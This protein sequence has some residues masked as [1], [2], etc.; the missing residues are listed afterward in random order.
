MLKKSTQVFKKHEN[1]KIQLLNNLCL[2]L[3]K[4]F[5]IFKQYDL[6]KKHT[7]KNLALN[8]DQ[9]EKLCMYYSIALTLCPEMKC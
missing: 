7:L 4:K 8:M 9:F 6:E 1:V 5:V 2:L 3:H